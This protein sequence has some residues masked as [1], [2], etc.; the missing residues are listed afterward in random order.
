MHL[1]KFKPGDII[2]YRVPDN[3]CRIYTVYGGLRFK[4]FYTLYEEGYGS[5]SDPINDVEKYAKLATEAE[6]I[7]YA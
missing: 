1:N 3:F 2:I 5:F 6:V 7:L 4:G